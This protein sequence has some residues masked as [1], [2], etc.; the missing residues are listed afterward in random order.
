MRSLTKNLPHRLYLPNTYVSLVKDLRS[1]PKKKSCG[2]RRGDLKK[3]AKGKP[4]K[5]AIAR[6]IHDRTIM[7]NG[8][9]AQELH[10]GDPSRVS[11]YCSAANEMN[12]IEKLLKELE[13]SIGK[14]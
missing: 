9:I 7:T 1:E 12:M 2:L 10:M 14:A 4:E 8:W 13:M 5:I 6:L 11:R 3:M